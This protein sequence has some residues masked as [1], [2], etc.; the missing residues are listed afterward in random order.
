MR[1]DAT[2]TTGSPRVEQRLEVRAVAADEDA[3]HAIVPMT[4]SPGSASGDDRAEADAE[5]E[6]AAQLILVDVA[7]E[8]LEH[9]RPLPCVPVD[10]GRAAGGEDAREVAEDAAAGDVRERARATAETA[11][12]VEVEACRRKEIGPS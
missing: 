11:R 6:D 5:I 7:R 8:P 12:D 1:F 9:G 10:L 4:S 2:A 3:D